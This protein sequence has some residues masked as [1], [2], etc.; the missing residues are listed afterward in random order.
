MLINFLIITEERQIKTIIC[1]I[2]RLILK[3]LVVVDR[4]IP[5]LMEPPT[6]TLYGKER[7]K[8]R[9]SL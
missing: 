4:K 2:E 7:K 1:Q 5:L 6:V 8:E 9:W 3:G